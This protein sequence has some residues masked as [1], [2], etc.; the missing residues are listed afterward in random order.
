ML[1]NE[2]VARS[3]LRVD[4]RKWIL[5]KL[6]P[7]IYGDKIALTGGEGERLFT[8]PSPSDAMATLI[9]TLSPDAAKQP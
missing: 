1:N 3:K 7:K 6:L 5:S 4:S 2:F 9:A 8:P